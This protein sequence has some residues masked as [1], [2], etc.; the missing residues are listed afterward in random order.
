MDKHYTKHCGVI[1]DRKT[2]SDE[3]KTQAAKSLEIPTYFTKVDDTKFKTCIHLLHPI[4]SEYKEFSCSAHYHRPHHFT[5]HSCF[6]TK[7]YQKLSSKYTTHPN[8]IHINIHPQIITTTSFTYIIL[9]NMH[10]RINIHIK[11][12]NITVEFAWL[13]VNVNSCVLAYICEF[14]DRV[15]YI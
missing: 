9:Y 10:I 4:D 6:W 2:K 8:Q 14:A 15:A 12:S 13:N 11:R 7:I 1:H 5:N 3:N